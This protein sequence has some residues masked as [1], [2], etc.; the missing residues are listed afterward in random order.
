MVNRPWHLPC[1]SSTIRNDA[2]ASASRS[3]RLE[4]PGF[5]GLPD[6]GGDHLQ[7]PLPEDPQLPGVVVHGVPDQRRL[8]IRRDLRV[9]VG[10]QRLDRRDDH[11]GLVHQQPTLGQRHPDRLERL[12]AQRRG[13]PGLAVRR[14]TG[15]LGWRAPTSSPCEVAPESA[16]TSTV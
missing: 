14:G 10:G 15:L 16:S 11:L 1:P 7:D 12:R 4:E 13:E 8:R 9:E 3:S 5:V 6:L 2:A